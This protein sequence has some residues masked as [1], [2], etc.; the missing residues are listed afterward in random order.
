MIDH[1]L[2]LLLGAAA[3]LML[4][5]TQVMQSHYRAIECGRAGLV[6]ETGKGCIPDPKSIIIERDL[7][8]G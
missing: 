3:V 2:L 6:Y 5:A 8:R 7:K 1:R 4:S